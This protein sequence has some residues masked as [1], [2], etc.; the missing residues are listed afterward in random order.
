MP[1]SPSNPSRTPRINLSA[2]STIFAVTVGVWLGLALIKFGNPI[3][4]DHLVHDDTVLS[5]ITPLTLESDPDPSGTGGSTWLDQLTAPWPYAWGFWIVCLLGM[6]SVGMGRPRGKVSWLLPG[7]VLAW[8]LWQCIA[9]ADSV[10]GALSRITLLHF[11]TCVACFLMGYFVLSRCRNHIL[12]WAGLSIG[13]LIVFW[14]AFQQHYGG[15]DAIRRLVYEQ[16]PDLTQLPPEYLKR[17]SSGR[18]FGTLVYPNA[19]AGV[20]LMLLPPCLSF[21]WIVTSRIPRVVRGVIL[22]L[23]SYTG[24]ACLVWSGSK[25]GWI[26]AMILAI[27]V[28]LH[29]PLGRQTKVLL[30]SSLLVGGLL[31]FGFRYAGYFQRGATSASARMDYWRAAVRIALAHP[32]TGTGPGTYSKAYQAVK[33]SQSEM[34]RLTHN[35]YLQQAADSGWPGFITYSAFITTG[36]VQLY[37]KRR[38]MDRHWHWVGLGILGWSLHS[39]VEFGLYIPAIAWTAFVSFGWLNSKSHDINNDIVVEKID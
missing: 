31:A 13:M 4:L 33:S 10:D 20:I 12:T 25:A 30:V 1:T 19:L 32:L 39:L 38:R 15:L 7:A 26:I 8:F 11:G 5:R 24:C 22:G 17:L 34:T 21:L 29:M 37:R 14:V 23:Y 36:A 2:W 28:L 9:A 35:D 16:S 3:I 6:A 27:V 18:V